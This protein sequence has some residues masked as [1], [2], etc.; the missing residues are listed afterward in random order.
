MLAEHDYAEFRYWSRVAAERGSDAALVDYREARY[1]Y[2]P[3]V[4]NIDHED[5]WPSWHERVKAVLAPINPRAAVLLSQ[6][7][8]AE[9][10]FCWEDDHRATW[11]SE[12]DKDVNAAE[13]AAEARADMLRE[14]GYR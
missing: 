6:D 9:L 14:E 4:E 12:L 11:Q 5:Y 7:D 13:Y 8:V 1:E 2:G 10:V 3:D